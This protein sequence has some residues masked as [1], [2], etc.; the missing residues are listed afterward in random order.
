MGTSLT[1]TGESHPP[2]KPVTIVAD[3]TTSSQG[4]LEY[5]AIPRKGSYQYISWGCKV[6]NHSVVKYEGTHK[7]LNYEGYGK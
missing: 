3:Q 6:R 4:L 2:N 5:V 1:V 7:Q